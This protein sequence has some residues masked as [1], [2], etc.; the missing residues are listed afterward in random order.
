MGTERAAGE[1]KVM[2]QLQKCV[3]EKLLNKYENMGERES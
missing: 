2:I 1:N 3:F